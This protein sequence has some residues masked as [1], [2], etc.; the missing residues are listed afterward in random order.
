MDNILQGD[1]LSHLQDVELMILKDFVKICEE[2]NIEYYL[3]FV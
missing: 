2:N 3:I 1:V